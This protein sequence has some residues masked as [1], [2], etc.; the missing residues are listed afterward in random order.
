[1][2]W[3]QKQKRMKKDIYKNINL[4]LIILSVLLVEPFSA[5]ALTET[6]QY[7]YDDVLQ[8]MDIIYNDG[9][10]EEYVY[11]NM[12]NR[13]QKAITLTGAPANNPPN[14]VSNPS[15][16]D[17]VI[18]VSITPTLIWT[19]GGDPDGDPV[20]YYLY[21]STSSTNPSL[22]TSTAQTNVTPLK[23]KSNTTY[24]WKVATRDSHNAST[25][26]P[27][28]SF[29]TKNDPPVASF[30]SDVTVGWQ[31]LTVHFKDTSTDP[32]GDAIVTW[33][34][35]FNNDGLIDSTEQRPT[36]MYN[37]KGTYNIVLKVTDFHGA[38]DTMTI[39]D[40]I[41]VQDDGDGDMVEDVSDNCP[42][43]F[44]PE[45]TDLDGDG[46]GDLCDPDTDGDGYNNDVDV[47]PYL[48]S[49]N[50]QAD[51][52]GD[53]YG[54]ACTVNHCVATSAE[55]QASL[56]VASGNNMGN[57]IRLVQGTYRISDNNNSTFSYYSSQS[58]NLIMLGG[59]TAGCASRQLDPANTVFDGEGVR[60][61][62]HMEDSAYAN[63]SEI[64]I[65]G[66]T[67]RNGS[68]GLQIYSSYNSITLRN[69]IIKNNSYSMFGGGII[70]NALRGRIMLS[71]NIIQS[72]T[73]DSYAGAYL[74]SFYGEIVLTNNIITGNTANSFG[75]G[76]SVD[77]T[78]PRSKLR[79]INNTIT[80][81][82]VLSDWGFGGGFLIWMYD[83][84]P[85]ADI[86]NNI[87]WGN[88][89]YKEG[90]DVFIYNP[91][92][93]TINAFNND[94]DPAKVSGTFTSAGNNI[95]ISPQFVASAN[96][97][98]HLS[99]SSPCIDAGDASAPSMPT[100][101][102]EGNNRVLGI[103]ADI[104]ADE[105]YTA[106][107]AYTI[108]GQIISGGSGLA[109]IQVDLTGDAA[110]TRVTDDS[111]NYR[112][113]WIS[114]G[115]YVITPV[116][117]FYN[118]APA[119]Y[120]IA[121][122]GTDITDRDF[123][124]TPKD[125]DGD[126]VLDKDDNCLD[127]SNTSQ[128][129]TDIDGYGDA[130]DGPGSI[131]GRITDESTGLGILGVWVTASETGGM[132][133]GEAY[134][135]ATGNYAITG[136]DNANYR[137]YVYKAAYI[138][139]YYNDTTNWSLAT[140]VTVTPGADSPSVDIALSPDTDNDGVADAI[141][142][143]PFVSNANQGDMDG[144][145][146][147]DVC[148][149]DVDGD[150]FNND[151]D[152]C[153]L[154]DN[155]NNQADSDG[156]GY[157]DACTI[158]HCVAN[159]TE[160]DNALNEASWNGMSDVI[161]LVQGT[162]GISGSMYGVFQYSSIEPYSLVIRGG[163][164]AGCVTRNPDPANT[165]LDGESYGTVLNL[166]TYGSSQFTKV[167]VEGVTV[168]NG[169]GRGINISTSSGEVVVTD[170][171]IKNNTSDSAIY[172]YADAGTV[173][174]TNNIIKNNTAYSYA[175]VNVSTNSGEA[176]LTNN[177]ITNNWTEQQAGGIYAYTTGGV[178]Q[179]INNTITA[180]TADVTNWG[181]GGGLYLSL[182]S[183]TAGVNIYN[184]II[185]G[186]T[187]YEGGDTYINNSQSGT[188]NALNNDFDPAKVFGTFT[189]NVN[190]INI[191]PQFVDAV[192][193]D[194]HLTG[195]S[196]C[197]N[198]GNST[199]PSLP[200]SD[201]EGN[202][203]VLGGTPDIGADEYYAA[204]S[205]F[206]ISGQILSEGSALSG[207]MV[208]LS[209]DFSAT[210]F[211]D[212]NGNY[213]FTGIGDGSYTVTTINA[214]YTY[215][216]ADYAII[217]SGANVTER[218]FTATPK[219]TDG[220]GVP[221]FSDNCV[222]IPNPGQD[223]TDSDGVG[224]ACD[225]DVLPTVNP[226]GPYTGIEGQAITLDGSGSGIP[227]GRT[228]TLYEWDVDSDGIYDYSSSLPTQTHVY[229]QNGFYYVSLRVTDNIS[230][231]NEAMTTADISDTSPTVGFR[232]SSTTGIEP[233]T[234]NFTDTSTSYDGISYQMWDF[235]DGNSGSGSTVSNV[236]YQNGTYSVTL[237]ITDND[238]STDVKTATITVTDTS[239]TAD[240]TGNPT[241]G[242]APFTVTFTNNSTA[243]DQPLTCEWDFD[244][245]GITDSYE[246]NP[247]HFY[248]N[249]GI[250]T[251]K[252]TVTD[253]DWS[254][255]NTLTRTNYIYVCAAPV[256]ILGVT[257]LYFPTLQEAY[258]IAEDG[259][260]IQS[261]VVTLTENLNINMDKTVTIKG[262]Y[263][264]S[265]TTQTGKTTINGTINII[266]GTA[267]IE[268][269]VLQ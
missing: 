19:G 168:R 66:V 12:G 255:P 217:V 180:N 187:G 267:T 135:D 37:A 117:V 53:G 2:K 251:V 242:T 70:A 240:F 176:V 230:V 131:S 126:G 167:K 225:T 205:A 32:D 262:G 237:T 203:R 219:D 193:G 106:G 231:T 59:Y 149:P 13:M 256:R 130:C 8:I 40:Y 222:N 266:D 104:G 154:L 213:L 164:T 64:M 211:T 229:S 74:N 111:G 20:V 105:Y 50:N 94:F 226:N 165:I 188:I 196:A 166:S 42:N 250:Y 112:F 232:L 46:L 158:N 72:N 4:L 81:N 191:D 54:D 215:T 148:D 223:D 186:N 157:G 183:S 128:V 63:L 155:D 24:Y 189:T 261:Q 163:Y 79:F 103:S 243:Y 77:L 78:G 39:I 239:P 36:Y 119:D 263:D 23:L 3:L 152:V 260:I 55:L 61:V 146:V 48:Y 76:V 122:S 125:T 95:N 38:T 30:A 179:L 254:P 206:A 142:N 173:R 199:A 269:L 98:Y 257:P 116:N 57:I 245:D 182:G 218:D 43:D 15:I 161:Q 198:A 234:V 235:G 26:G 87:I 75:G 28:W 51:S 124:A 127:V 216:P 93:G 241:S 140:L 69:N 220:D 34:W 170:S 45:Q 100:T 85:E 136:L 174:L 84:H 7:G 137:V 268:N 65:E 160:F 236:Y 25:D 121:V 238:G 151:A 110:A 73:A 91:L 156:D 159:V 200:A 209:G 233:L 244:N 52:D 56:S 177:I 60:Q 249:P 31:P 178:I 133:W 108:S 14:P 144:D 113:T 21:L 228:I 29:T 86:Y 264:C 201:Y 16:P 143:C 41:T 265:Y 120:A 101:D 6:I 11:D 92:S 102:Y 184:N 134:T 208:N 214:F 150:G 227:E 9:T 99:S 207:I 123:T 247:L 224:D 259:D 252:L 80:E 145:S 89:A 58:G 83:F 171:I 197:I 118:Y 210:R 33:E 17:G 138:N 10:V 141:D 82:R 47:C 109:G 139:E 181:S 1:L 253:S 202:E 49:D 162:Y 190:N 132:F 221:D 115:N 147:G 248:D 107:D 35:D 153:P 114:D 195:G 88:S 67:I 246:A 62:L 5:Y 27:L 204:G 185:W 212:G 169:A 192:N 175:G 44:N 90:G 129:D 258:D 18:D 22:V 172:A 97:D 68:T 96:G 71:E 194:Y